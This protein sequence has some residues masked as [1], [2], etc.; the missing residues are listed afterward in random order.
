MRADHAGA[1]VS[2]VA[3]SDVAPLPPAAG[4]S[5]AEEPVATQTID[6]TAGRAVY[7]WL[8]ARHAGDRRR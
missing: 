1:D 7:R 3:T 4:G 8:S 6:L 2:Y 5:D